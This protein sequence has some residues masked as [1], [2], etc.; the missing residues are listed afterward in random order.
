MAP[1][2]GEVEVRDRLSVFLGALCL[3]FTI[4][5][6]LTDWLQ[7]LLYFCYKKCQ[8]FH[9]FSLLMKSFVCGQRNATTASTLYLHL[10]AFTIQITI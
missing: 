10:P 2:Q 5:E 9:I 6:T 1:M 8:I 3:C 7:E 4:R